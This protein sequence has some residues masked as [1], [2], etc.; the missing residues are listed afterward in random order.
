MKNLR[1]I[2]CV[3]CTLIV[4]F[5]ESGCASA[6]SSHAPVRELRTYSIIAADDQG[7]L[8]QT[9][10]NSIVDTLVQFLLDQGYVRT[11][12][13]LI[14]DPGRAAVVFRMKIAWNEGRT[15]F[16][17]VSV[18]PGS[19]GERVYAETP[20]AYATSAPPPDAPPPDNGWNDDPWC[21]NDGFGYAYGPYW[22]FFAWFPFVSYHGIGRHRPPPSM[23]R[24]PPDHSRLSGHRPQQW[25][26]YRHYVSPGQSNGGSNPQLSPQEQRQ[27]SAGHD[28][29]ASASHRNNPAPDHRA[30][31][32]NPSSSRPQTRDTE[33]HP[34]PD[35]PSRRPDS[36]VRASPPPTA[37][38][39]R[40][41][42]PSARSSPPPRRETSPAERNSTPP[43]SHA[44]PPASTSHSD[45]DSKSKTH[46]RDH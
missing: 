8:S 43:V 3:L 7:T 37:V 1:L 35:H 33:H 6:D 28:G 5:F 20:P 10:L 36:N 9:E 42:A 39:A 14:D 11:D 44:S 2:A 13:I 40:E 26:Q 24:R 45:T 12:Q 31:T 32:A 21:N 38:P 30:R 25:G 19:G 18:V 23:I 34:A 22:P 17:V 16:A 27:F 29:S 4:A 15:S 41:P 46:D